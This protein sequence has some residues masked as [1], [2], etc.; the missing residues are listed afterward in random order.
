[1]SSGERGAAR[2]FALAAVCA[3]GACG[4][5]RDLWPSGRDRTPPVV[6]GTLGPAVGQTAPD[7]SRPDTVG[8]DHALYATLATAPAVILYFNMWCPICDAHM[9][10]LQRQVVPAFPAVPVW[11]V[12]YVLDGV[13]ASRAAQLQSGWGSAP[14]TFLVDAGGAVEAF[15]QA[16]MALVVIGADHVVRYNG[17]YDWHRLQPVLAALGTAP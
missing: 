1:M 10:D 4:V 13:A 3:L 11:V 15:Y 7:F 16:P 9:L 12:D 8:V 2:A 14:F 5:D 17:E 6:A